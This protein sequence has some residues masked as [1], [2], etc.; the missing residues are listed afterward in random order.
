MNKFQ[1]ARAALAEGMEPTVKIFGSSME[2]LIEPGSLATFRKT[3]D[4]QVGDVV[5]AKVKGN[6]CV[7]KIAKT[8]EGKGR[9]MIAN[10]HGHENGWTRNVYG[11]VIK[12]NGKE[13]GR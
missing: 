5:L 11:R 9:F 4:Y 6:W 1:V 12:I 13:F 8:D 10:N 2:P 7:H 3:D